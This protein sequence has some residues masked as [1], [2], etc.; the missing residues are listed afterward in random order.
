MGEPIIDRRAA[1]AALLARYRDGAAGP[2]YPGAVALTCSR[3]SAHILWV[4]P[5]LP[6]NGETW[7]RQC[8]AD[9]R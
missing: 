7:C 2:P 3:C 5:P 6:P 8:S 1:R 9:S 4:S